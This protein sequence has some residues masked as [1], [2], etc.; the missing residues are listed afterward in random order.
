[1]KRLTKALRF[2]G[3]HMIKGNAPSNSTRADTQPPVNTEK[4]ATSRH[5]GDILWRGTDEELREALRQLP[6]GHCDLTDYM[7]RT[8]QVDKLLAAV[9]QVAVQR[10]SFGVTEEPEKVLKAIPHS[11]VREWDFFGTSRL[12]RD[13]KSFPFPD[14]GEMA[15]LATAV[16]QL[17]EHSSAKQV[18]INASALNDPAAK[19]Q[20]PKCFEGRIKPVRL[21]SCK[22]ALT[23]PS[24]QQDARASSSVATPPVQVNADKQSL[25]RQQYAEL[26]VQ[27]VSAI[28]AGKVT[29]TQALIRE[30]IANCSREQF[31]LIQ[32]NAQA[33][34]ELDDRATMAAA[35]ILKLSFPLALE[36][37]GLSKEDFAKLVTD[38]PPY[39]R[40]GSS[41]GRNPLCSA[42]DQLLPLSDT[43]KNTLRRLATNYRFDASE[44]VQAAALATLDLL[45]K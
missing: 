24:P 36:P 34:A 18:F 31:E 32:K 45:E 3:I 14:A 12:G 16:S 40:S 15:C 7:L 39:I 4:S 30:K 6:D 37:Q 20:F 22:P 5:I 29:A 28:G 41:K 44:L 9:Q 1:M 17:H 21:F 26:L 11:L 8:S 38:L 19:D 25:S 2:L 42:D 27:L 43:Q 23:T 10:I 35:E 13:N 33:L